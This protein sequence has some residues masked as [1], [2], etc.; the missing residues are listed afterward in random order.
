MTKGK[1]KGMFPFRIVCNMQKEIDSRKIDNIITDISDIVSNIL[2]K[3]VTI[4]YT[5]IDTEE[6][7]SVYGIYYLEGT[8][9]SYPG[10]RETPPE[11]E[12]EYNLNIDEKE[13]KKRLTKAY[14]KYLF[15]VD[16]DEYPDEEEI[17]EN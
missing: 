14:K 3:E 1:I 10:D 11:F 12:S 2:K 5:M 17:L 15:E 16:F 7:F 13:L 9:I 8:Y 6:S 4:K